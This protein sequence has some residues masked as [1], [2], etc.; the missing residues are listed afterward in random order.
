MM[1]V[2]EHRESLGAM[3]HLP[4]R[5]LKYAIEALRQRPLMFLNG[6]SVTDLL[7]FSR[8]TVFG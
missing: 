8:A 3:S 7:V 5:T 2:Q 4:Q 1:A 6:E